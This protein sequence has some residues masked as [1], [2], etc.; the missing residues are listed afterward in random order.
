[1]P[2]F[3]KYIDSKE[4]LLKLKEA[5][6]LLVED[7]QSGNLDPGV[8]QMFYEQ[9]HGGG[10]DRDRPCCT[11]GHLFHRA[12]LQHDVNK[13]NNYRTPNVMFGDTDVAAA[14]TAVA[15]TN[16]GVG[17]KVSDPDRRLADLA[18]ELEKLEGT[19]K[20]ALERL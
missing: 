18:N 6:P 2:V 10:I 8:D 13:E 15:S 3:P 17:S 5:I 20:E 14:V 7:L 11:M 4:N 12:G 19:I 1:M 9:H 16:D